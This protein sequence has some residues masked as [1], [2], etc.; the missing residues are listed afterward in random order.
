MLRKFKV[1]KLDCSIFLQHLFAS[2]VKFLFAAV[3]DP[4]NLY[5]RFLNVSDEGIC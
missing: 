5:T 3:S 4:A 2:D 1:F